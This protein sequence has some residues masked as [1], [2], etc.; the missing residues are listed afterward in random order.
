M[1]KLIM[2]E[3]KKFKLFNYWKAVSICNIAIIAVLIMTYFIEIEEGLEIF[4]NFE[5]VANLIGVMVRTT[6]TI[7]ASVLIV[8]LIID[9]YKNKSIDVLFSYPIKRKRI[10]SAKLTIV[11]MFTFTIVLISTLLLEGLVLLVDLNFN[12]LPGEVESQDMS[13]HLLTVFMNSLATAGISL[14]PLLVGMRRKSGPAT[15]VTSILIATILNSQNM[16]FTLFS[17]IEFHYH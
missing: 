3:I 6:F 14:I 11:F 7:F 9:E 16:G 1:I 13:K 8:K 15:I 17:I 5:M 12:V 10:F 2:L 4:V